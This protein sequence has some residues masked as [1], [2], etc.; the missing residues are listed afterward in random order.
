M[1][2]MVQDL[3]Y[4]FRGLRNQPSFTFLAALALALGIGSATTIFSVISRQVSWLL[5]STAHRFPIS[6]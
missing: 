3:R 2:S 6:A 4:G 5:N 1:N